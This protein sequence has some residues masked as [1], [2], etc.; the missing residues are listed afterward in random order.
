MH[1]LLI[2]VLIFTAAASLFV[3]LFK[4]LKLGAILAY[5]F[6]GIVIGP[7]ALGLITDTE[8]ILHFSELGVV[9]LLFLIGL[10]LAPQKLWRL[11]KAIFGLGLLQV[12]ITGVVLSVLASLFG[13]NNAQSL[14][15][16]FGLSLSSTAFVVQLLEE[17]NELKTAYG[18]G[19][20]G[21]LM[22]QDLAI[23]PLLALLSFLAST[24]ESQF[25]M[26]Q[27]LI[28]IGTLGILIAVG[29][30][31]VRHVLRNVANSKTQETFTAISLFIVIG[32][33][34]LVEHSGL[35]MAMGAFL[36]GVLL[37]N[38]E[39][40]HELEVNLL[41]FKGLLLGLFFIA[42]GMALNLQVIANKP[43]IVIGIC[44][45]LLAIK[46]TIIFLLAL[47]FKFPRA[48]AFKMAFVLPQG[49]EFAFVLFNAAVGKQVFGNDLA[50]L[51]NAAVTLSMAITPFLYAWNKNRVKLIEPENNA[52]YDQIDESHAEVIIA[53]FGRFG[54]IV[55]RFL[56]A[57]KV[58]FI[59][60]EHNA[61]QVETARKFGNKVYYGDATRAD[62]LESADIKNAKIFILAIVDLKTSKA[63]AQYVK[64][65]YPHIKIMARV[66]NRQHAIAMMEIGVEVIHRE[67]FL[68]SLEV[69]KEVMLTKGLSAEKVD[70]QIEKFIR[71]DEQILKK[72]YELRNDDEG[73]LSYTIQANKELDN[74]LD[75]DE[76]TK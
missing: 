25:S 68:T 37:A 51:L 24:G 10:E 4:K 58:S 9:F 22:F 34:L 31:L 8:T 54:Q 38:S 1:S 53:G 75:A 46:A 39:Y 72:Q 73:F 33:G 50:A 40:R 66:R 36:A 11:R 29:P 49:G 27:I 69:A 43:L 45:G 65:K 61:A 6:A 30:Y 71:K 21:I 12:F 44:I 23:V 26:N 76:G 67:T 2:D 59:I 14:V 57:Q 42:V 35:S 64:K 41:P 5:L 20:F 55:A 17:N 63:I 56:K 48:S 62:I 19:A 47:G 70:K 28:S 15:I 16:G 32:T 7:H 52:K 60:L 18:Q 3:P 74:I 13:M